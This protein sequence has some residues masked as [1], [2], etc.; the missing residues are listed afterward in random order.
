MYLFFHFVEVKENRNLSLS[1]SLRYR[2]VSVEKS[3]LGLSYI[4]CPAEV[5]EVGERLAGY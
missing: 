3:R 1:V 4:S 5:G 2:R